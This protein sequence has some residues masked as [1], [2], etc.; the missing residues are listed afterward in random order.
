MVQRR[1]ANPINV[2]GGGHC[3]NADLADL[4]DYRMMRVAAC[5]IGLHRLSFCG[6]GG[7]RSGGF[8]ASVY[9]RTKVHRYRPADRPYSCRLAL[10]RHV[11][12]ITLAW[13]YAQRP[14]VRDPLGHRALRRLLQTQSLPEVWDRPRKD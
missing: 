4:S 13:L 2:W 7:G 10:L 14:G 12:G 6:G 1:L 8:A 3:L 9:G 11:S 5:S